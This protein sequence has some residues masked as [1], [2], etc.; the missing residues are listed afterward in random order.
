LTKRSRTE[1]IFRRYFRNFRVSV[2][3]LTLTYLIR[4]VHIYMWELYLT[5]KLIRNG[6]ER[7][8]RNLGDY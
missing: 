6:D 2:P 4:N 5:G 8:N 1:W 3:D 7:L